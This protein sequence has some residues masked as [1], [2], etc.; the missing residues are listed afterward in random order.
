MTAKTEPP[1][2]AKLLE[3]YDASQELCS[4]AAE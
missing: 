1:A 2:P 3:Q 4:I